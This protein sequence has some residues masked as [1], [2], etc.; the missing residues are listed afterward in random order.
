VDGHAI[1]RGTA[2]GV[3][4]YSLLHDADYFPEPFAF[5]P[6]RWLGAEDYERAK[7]RRAFAPFAL[8]DRGY[9]GKAMAYLGSE[10]NGCEDFVVF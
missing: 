3:S 8:G 10:L 4:L 6:E 9:A 1:P 2:V 7:I 5:R